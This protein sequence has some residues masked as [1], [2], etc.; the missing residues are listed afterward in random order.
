MPPGWSASG[1][2]QGGGQDQGE[3]RGILIKLTG[4]MGETSLQHAGV[5]ALTWEQEYGGSSREG[6]EEGR[7]LLGRGSTL[8]RC[9][10]I[11]GCSCG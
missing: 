7:K 11:G 9:C 2:P 6:A 1:Y 5:F 10:K 4:E 8:G 3:S